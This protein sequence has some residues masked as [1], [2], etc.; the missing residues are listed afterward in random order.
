MMRILFILLVATTL[1]GDD[2]LIEEDNE[3]YKHFVL[4]AFS[5]L[6]QD[7]EYHSEYVNARSKRQSG[8]GFYAL[9]LPYLPGDVQSN[10][11][12]MRLVTD[13]DESLVELAHSLFASPE[14]LNPVVNFQQ[15]GNPA[16]PSFDPFDLYSKFSPQSDDEV[17]SSIQDILDTLD[18]FEE[19]PPSD[20]NLEKP[21]SPAPPLGYPPATHSPKPQVQYEP[22]KPTKPPHKPLPPVSYKPPVQVKPIQAYT[23]QKPQAPP[24]VYNPKLP[25]K[26][27]TPYQPQKPYQPIRQPPTHVFKTSTTEAPYRR[28][29]TRTSIYTTQHTPYTTTPKHKVTHP[30]KGKPKKT[31]TQDS[32]YRQ[33]YTDTATK[34]SDVQCSKTP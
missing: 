32:T 27:P 25:H 26:P 7:R 14:V 20:Q 5:L 9:P 8:A 29:T 22:P 30:Y 4:S 23:P 34:V 21:Y 15:P 11:N 1:N 2:E 19:F 6:E 24:V 10:L 17:P 3:M 31:P 33:T 18:Q 16:V 12:D 13:I 28:L